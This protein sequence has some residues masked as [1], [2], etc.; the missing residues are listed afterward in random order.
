MSCP[1][2]TYSAHAH[3]SG[4]GVCF[5]RMLRSRWWSAVSPGGPAAVTLSLHW[6]RGREGRWREDGDVTSKQRKKHRYCSGSWPKMRREL[7]LV[8]HSVLFLLCSLL[9]VRVRL[10]ACTVRGTVPSPTPVS[11]EYRRYLRNLLGAGPGTPCCRPRFTTEEV[12]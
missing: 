12:Q 10:H 7:R 2:V 3:I 5:P 8:Q 6:S 9:H 11:S 1:D 4:G